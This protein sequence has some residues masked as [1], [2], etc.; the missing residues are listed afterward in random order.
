MQRHILKKH[1]FQRFSVCFCDSYL[2]K[3]DIGL[4][5][6]A[7]LKYS[8]G[9]IRPSMLLLMDCTLIIVWGVWF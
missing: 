4:A 3:Y 7:C 6:I 5:V 9:N 8:S 2:I 1:V